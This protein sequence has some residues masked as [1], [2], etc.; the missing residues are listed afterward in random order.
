MRLSVARSVSHL[1]RLSF[2]CVSVVIFLQ[3]WRLVEN[4]IITSECMKVYFTQVYFTL[5]SP[6][7]FKK[8]FLKNVKKK[9]SDFETHLS[10][11]FILARRELS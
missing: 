8:D 5:Y 1:V 11:H 2:A 4:R 9:I 7:A 6:F 3:I 10:G